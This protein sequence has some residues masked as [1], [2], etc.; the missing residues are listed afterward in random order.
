M[1]TFIDLISIT[2]EL[3]NTLPISR[4]NLGNLFYTINPTIKDNF[5]QYLI[6]FMNDKNINNN[7]RLYILITPMIGEYKINND[8]I[9][10]VFSYL[11][12]YNLLKPNT[13]QELI[14]GLFNDLITG[15]ETD[16]VIIDFQSFIQKGAIEMIIL[17][18]FKQQ[19]YDKSD[20]GGTLSDII[21]DHTL[22]TEYLSNLENRIQILLTVNTYL[23][24][25]NSERYI[26][27]RD[28]L[29]YLLE[30][31]TEKI[32]DFQKQK[33]TAPRFQVGDKVQ[34]RDGVEEWRMG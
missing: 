14:L 4:F 25:V 29:N 5:Q 2:S 19:Y 24:D 22:V 23:K 6:D 16:E 27:D 34:R 32:S 8:V 33:S 11:L 26:I 31:I 10:N 3:W 9:T 21:N 17:R 7:D 12:Y 15:V 18:G 28:I 13:L 30:N 1:S 20:T